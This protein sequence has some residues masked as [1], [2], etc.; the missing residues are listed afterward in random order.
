MPGQLEEDDRVKEPAFRFESFDRG[1]EPWF[2][3][4]KRLNEKYGL[5]L[6]AQYVTLYQGANDST[7][8]EEDTFSG[9]LRVFGKWSIT[10]KG[11]KN[12]GSLVFSVDHRH[13]FTRIS[14]SHYPCK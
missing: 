2:N 9:L 11:T 8:G 1:L 6:G 4:K 10:G 14:R 7:T 3:W 12:T 5:Q 13:G